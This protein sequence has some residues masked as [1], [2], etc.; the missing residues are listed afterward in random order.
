MS[1]MR[2]GTN[3]ALLTARSN[4]SSGT[5]H[6]FCSKWLSE[7]KTAEYSTQSAAFPLY[8]LNDA[9]TG[10]SRSNNS[11]KRPNFSSVFMKDLS[12][13]LQLP[14]NAQYSLPEG[15]TPEDVFNYAYA[16]FYSPNYRSRY[17][18]FLKSD[19]PRLPLTGS[20]GLFN[21]LALLGGKL[22]ALHL[23]EL[24]KLE[25]SSTKFISDGNS[26]VE[27]ISWSNNTVWINKTHTTGFKGVPETV[28]NFHIGGYQVCDKWL[29]DRKGR[30]LSQADLAHY[31]KIVF[32]L[33][34]T[35][36]LMQEIDDVIENHGGWPSAFQTDNTKAQASHQNLLKF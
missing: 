32:A 28:W 23:M 10:Q 16:I 21:A 9:I 11:T 36:R 30:K 5:D 14:Q 25:Q 29:K 34:E 24:P 2:P 17:A 27:K 19:F 8:F 4:K 33:T 3:L 22:V 1:H 15:L 18:E 12:T 26:E 20:L 35:I 7:A 13:S 31:Q 6:F